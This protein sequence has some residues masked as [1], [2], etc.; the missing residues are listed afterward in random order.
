MEFNGRFVIPMWVCFRKGDA[1]ALVV[2]EDS[3]EMGHFRPLRSWGAKEWEHFEDVFNANYVSTL[4][5][6]D[7][8]DGDLTSLQLCGEMGW[9]I[10]HE[11]NNNL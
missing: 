4:R 6:Q 2:D 10:Q 9:S 8:E 5:P 7:V 1:G 11:F 3:G